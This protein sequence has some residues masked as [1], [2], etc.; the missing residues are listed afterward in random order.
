MPAAQ[1]RSTVSP[2]GVDLVDEDD[3]RSILLALLEQVADAAGTDPDEHL[4]KV[5]PGNGEERH[6]RFAHT[7]YIFE[8]HF[9]LL[10][11]VQPG[12]A[13]AE[14]EG[15]VSAALHL[16]HHEDPEREQ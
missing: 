11:G 16:A 13:L 15:F 7:G 1:A 5:R 12:T 4:H 2:N 8:R 6:L 3:A 10:G 9:L 14:T